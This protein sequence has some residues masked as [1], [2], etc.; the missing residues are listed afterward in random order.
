MEAKPAG[1]ETIAVIMMNKDSDDDELPSAGGG[2]DC[3]DAM[4]F[5]DEEDDDELFEL[6]ISL[7][8]GFDDDDDVRDRKGRH[9]AGDGAHALLANCLLPVSSVSMAVPVMAS[10]TVSPCFAFS[11][12]TSRRRFGVGGSGRRKFGRAAA[13]GG[14]SS[15]AR[16]R[17]SSRGFATVGNFQR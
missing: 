6:D 10:D 5:T 17:L 12:Y 8:R 14:Y 2:S 15:W 13:D 4:V 11:S 9:G 1:Q 7:L 3:H 16:F